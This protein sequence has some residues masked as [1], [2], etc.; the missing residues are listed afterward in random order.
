MIEMIRVGEL[1]T[2]NGL[3]I[4]FFDNTN[5]VMNYFIK[6]EEKHDV[7]C[8]Q[9]GLDDAEEILP[10]VNTYEKMKE[11]YSE[12]WSAGMVHGGLDKAELFFLQTFPY[13]IWEDCVLDNFRGSM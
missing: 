4:C 11:N 2:K 12:L 5:R 13:G 7:E 10:K 6:N 9:I 3:C 8:W 1:E